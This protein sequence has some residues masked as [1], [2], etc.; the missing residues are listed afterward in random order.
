MRETCSS[1]F[2]F[3][4]SSSSF[5]FLL[6]LLLL[7]LLVLL[8]M[9]STI[10]DKTTSWEQ[11]LAGVSAEHWQSNDTSEDLRKTM[12]AQLATALLS[13]PDLAQPSFSASTLGIEGSQFGAVLFPSAMPTEMQPPQFSAD[14]AQTGDAQLVL[15]LWYGCLAVQGLKEMRGATKARRKK[16]VLQVPKRFKTQYEHNELAI[17]FYEQQKEACSFSKDQLIALKQLQVNLLLIIL[18]KQEH[19]GSGLEKRA[20][21]LLMAIEQ[22]T[23]VSPD[24]WYTFGC[25]LRDEEQWF[26]SE[27][28]FR[29]ATLGFQLG[30]RDLADSYY[31]LGASVV[32]TEVAKSEKA[33]KAV[34]FSPK[35][36]EQLRTC[37]TQGQKAEDAA[38]AEFGK[39]EN[40]DVEQDPKDMIQRIVLGM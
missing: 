10:E 35:I 13:H 18:K 29:K 34:N 36:I 21:S 7:V 28:C 3:L 32:C 8:S 30:A 9:D 27:M 40:M 39:Y 6:L 38:E 33:K 19:R 31:N 14:L 23:S 15:G 20:V 12:L 16:L 2:L 26:Y 22:T 37:L 24:Y 4:P 5:F 1:F 25:I 11:M 17:K